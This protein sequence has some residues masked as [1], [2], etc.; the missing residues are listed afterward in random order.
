ML[1]VYSVGSEKEAQDLLVLA[2]S[3]NYKGDFI[4]KELMHEQTIDNLEAFGDRL[5]QIHNDYIIK[6][7]RCYC[8][9]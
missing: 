9:Y 1:P 2:C 7:N 4:A 8:K 5:N 3:T 6:K